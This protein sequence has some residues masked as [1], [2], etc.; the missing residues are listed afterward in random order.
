[1]ASA[2]LMVERRRFSRVTKSIPV[3][4]LPERAQEAHAEAQ[5]EATAISRGGASLRVPFQPELGSRLAIR[6]G[7]SDEC[8]ECRVVRVSPAAKHD[9]LFEL[10]VEILHPA[11][12]F[13][14]V[15]FPDEHSHD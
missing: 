2:R 4:V 10:G 1:M 13:W 12:N 11:R 9:G 5:T 7:F 14:G 8:R 15:A 3:T 6:H